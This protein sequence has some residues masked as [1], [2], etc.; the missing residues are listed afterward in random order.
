[1]RRS[2]GVRV[3]LASFEMKIGAALEMILV[4]GMRISRSRLLVELEG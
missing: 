4:F 1:M 2:F 3:I